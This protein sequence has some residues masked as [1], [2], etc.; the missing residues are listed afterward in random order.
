MLPFQGEERKRQCP[1]WKEKGADGMTLGS[2][3]EG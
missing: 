2:R 1:F 3:T